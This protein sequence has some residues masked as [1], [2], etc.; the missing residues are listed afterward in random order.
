[1]EIYINFSAFL[2][3]LTV[4]LG[5]LVAMILWWYPGKRHLPYRRV[6]G[7]YFS[8]VALGFAASVIHETGLTFVIPH[9]FRMGNFFILLAPSLS[10]LYVRG[11]ITGKPVGWWDLI[12]TIPLLFYLVDFLPFLMLSASEKLEIFSSTFGDLDAQQAFTE[13][14]ITPPHFHRIL[15]ILVMAFYWGLQVW[16]LLRLMDLKDRK[17][18]IREN[19]EWLS[20]I[21]IFLGFQFFTFFPALVTSLFAS[22]SSEAIWITTRVV[23][24]LAMI[25]FILIVFF[26]PKMLYGL[27]GFIQ[28]PINDQEKKDSDKPSYVDEETVQELLGN[29]EDLMSNQKPYLN[30]NYLLSNL[31][32]D[33]N[34]PG[35]KLSPF[36]K[37]ETGLSFKDFI[38]KQRIDYCKEKLDSGEWQQYTVAAI[39]EECGFNNRNS[40]TL[41]FKKFTGVTPTVYL[42]KVNID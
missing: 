1:M 30:P 14:W 18:F 21:L 35:Y 24:G 7:G 37:Q 41:S 19:R 39:A 27:H 8:A 25:I 28:Y 5:L 26:R 36:L 34:L 9:T 42:Q 12:H 16:L 3:L 40:F 4:I 38:N 2:Q 22:D 13:G 29:L 6:L 31:S 23:Y 32:N 33:L 11:V 10:Y 20:F 17:L 15:L